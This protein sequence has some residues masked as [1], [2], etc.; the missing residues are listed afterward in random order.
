M[1]GGPGRC[2]ARS[3]PPCPSP[4]SRTKRNLWAYLPGR[5]SET[6]VVGSHL[7]SVPVGGWLDGALGVI[8]GLE[9]LRSLALQPE[10][11][12]LAAVV[13]WADE[14]GARFSRS[15]FGSAAVVGTLDVDILR[16]L[17]DRQGDALPEVLAQHGVNI[18]ALDGCRT[19]L[20]DVVADPELHIEQGPAPENT[21]AWA[22][23]S[24][25]ARSASNASG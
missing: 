13:D 18:E 23:V 21:V 20:D 5:T 9:V 8:G 12:A 16:G 2:C 19:R 7:D 1:G 24:S 15:L 4:W 25:R 14:E 11:P 17:K 10:P 3:W 22:S 6:V